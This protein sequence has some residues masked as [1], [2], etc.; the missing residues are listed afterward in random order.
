LK[1]LIND[2]IANVLGFSGWRIDGIYHRRGLIAQ[3]YAKH[4]LPI[5]IPATAGF[6]C[7]AF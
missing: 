1:S 5:G 7:L 6:S 4:Q 2:Q 3:D